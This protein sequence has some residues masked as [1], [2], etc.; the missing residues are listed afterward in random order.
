MSGFRGR[1]RS[2]GLSS[3][4]GSSFRGSGQ[5]PSVRRKSAAGHK[6]KRN[7]NTHDESTRDDDDGTSSTGSDIEDDTVA[8][9]SRAKGALRPTANQNDDA[10]AAAKL[11]RKLGLG[12]GVKGDDEQ[13]LQKRAAKLNKEFEG[14]FGDGFGDFLVGLDDISGPSEA[15]P[16]ATDA[17]A[18]SSSDSEYDGGGSG[19]ADGDSARGRAKAA[20][21]EAY[22]PPHMRRQVLAAPAASAVVAKTASLPSR[23]EASRDLYG[24]TA[25]SVTVPGSRGGAGFSALEHADAD[26]SRPSDARARIRKRMQGLIN[27]LSESNIEPVAKELETVYSSEAQVRLTDRCGT[28]VTSTHLSN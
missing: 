20:A 26:A 6:R 7:A 1:R 8:V 21:E 11:E 25:P 12:K 10:A 27:R 9:V 2:R 19:A 23:R 24:R 18:A 17:G 15:L 28:V 3:A 13:R 14:D 16:T 5:A 4:L 22:L